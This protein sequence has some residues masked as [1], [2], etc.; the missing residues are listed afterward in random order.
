LLL[1]LTIT[2]GSASEKE[3]P[4]ATTLTIEKTDVLLT[5]QGTTLLPN[6]PLFAL[7]GVLGAFYAKDEINYEQL[8]LLEEIIRRESD[9]NPKI[10]NQEFGCGSGMGLTQ[11]VPGTVKYCEEKLG[12]EIDP[13]NPEQNLECAIW[14]LTNEGIG[15][16]ESDDGSWGSGP[17]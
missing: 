9:G 3:Q 15:H 2:A 12:K 11:L 6:A 7:S 17:Y 10:C 4:R 14:L 8:L 13:F 16:W 1:F 5:I